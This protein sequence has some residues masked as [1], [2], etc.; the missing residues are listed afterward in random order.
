MKKLYE[1]TALLECAAV[2]AA[3]SEAEA[4]AAI[5]TWERAWIYRGDFIGVSDVKLSVVRDV[6]PDC[7]LIDLAHEIA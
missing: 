4:E 7:E 1:F 3:D 2:I 5:K 6:D